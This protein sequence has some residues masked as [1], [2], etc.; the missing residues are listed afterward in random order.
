MPLF[1]ALIYFNRWN[2]CSLLWILCCFVSGKFGILNFQCRTLKHFMKGL[3]HFGGI[4]F[5]KKW[6]ESFI[7]IKTC[8]VSNFLWFLKYAW[9]HHAMPSFH[10]PL[11]SRIKAKCLWSNSIVLIMWLLPPGYVR[12]LQFQ[13]L[14]RDTN[15]FKVVITN[16][17]LSTDDSPM[18][19]S[20]LKNEKLLQKAPHCPQKASAC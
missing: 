14:F 20:L 5:F 9:G 8:K 2:F 10:L 1:L 4:I 17:Q 18:T 3:L 16:P 13:L 12:E 15:V 6:P 7:H 11:W 19:T